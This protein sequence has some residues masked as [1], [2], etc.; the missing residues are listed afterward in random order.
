L[1]DGLTAGGVRLGDLPQEGPEDRAEVPAAVAGVGA[2]VLLGQ[3]VV[4]DPGF[5]EGLELVEGGLGG[6]AELLELL[7]KKGGES[8]EVGC[9]HH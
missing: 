7:S 6:G 3:A 8:G 1:V 9:P 2:L 4:R 5:K